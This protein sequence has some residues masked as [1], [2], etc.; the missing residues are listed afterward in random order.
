MPKKRKTRKQKENKHYDFS[1]VLKSVESEKEKKELERK[2]YQLDNLETKNGE[3]KKIERSF[4]FPDI[5]KIII[6]T[7]LI[8]IVMIAMYTINKQNDFLLHWS[9]SLMNFLVR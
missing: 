8:L 9:D 6:T 2:M 7:S 1:H 4:L 5:I 3:Q